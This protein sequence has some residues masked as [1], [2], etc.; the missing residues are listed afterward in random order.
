MRR[1]AFRWALHEADFTAASTIEETVL[2]EFPPDAEDNFETHLV[3][4][5]FLARCLSCGVLSSSDHDLLVLFKIH[6]VSSEIL[7]ARQR[8]SDVAFRHRM[9]RVIEKLRRAARARS[10][11]RQHTDNAVA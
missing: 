8:I 7:A 2:N 9:Q 1:S 3:L 5:E 4:T 6:G 10:M 11:S